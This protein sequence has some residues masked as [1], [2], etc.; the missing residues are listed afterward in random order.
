VVLE[1]EVVDSKG[2]RRI[3][4]STKA[5]LRDASGTIVGLV[6]I[7]FDITERKGTEDALRAAKAEAD[8]ANLGSPALPLHN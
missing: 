5:P 8:R 4:L 7:A 6:G 2:R 3:C 1:Q